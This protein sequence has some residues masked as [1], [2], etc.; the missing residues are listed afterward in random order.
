MDKQLEQNIKMGFVTSLMNYFKIEEDANLRYHILD[1]TRDIDK[2]R[3]REFFRRLSSG[4]LEYKNAFEKIASV[5][6]SFKTLE[7]KESYAKAKYLYD[8]MYELRRT[9]LLDATLED[10][11]KEFES[12]YI[13]KIKDKKSGKLL[14]GSEDV[15]VIKALGKRWIFDNVGGDKSFFLQ[16]C[17]NEYEKLALTKTPRLENRS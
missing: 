3:Y 14:L 17:A 7:H 16:V 6:K 12:I 4:E 2:S 9:L 10:A 13:A 1:L 15:A 5:A 11:A 8:I